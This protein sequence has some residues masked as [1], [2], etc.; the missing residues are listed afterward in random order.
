MVLRTVLYICMDYFCV[1][2]SLPNLTNA[3]F[4]WAAD[5]QLHCLLV[6]I[7]RHGSS[8]LTMTCKQ[9]N[10]ISATHLAPYESF[11]GLGY[12]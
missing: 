11:L 2:G 12:G 3:D 9:H 4:R 8:L 10:G 6:G 5:E 1:C 7:F